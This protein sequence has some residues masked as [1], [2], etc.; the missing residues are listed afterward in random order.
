MRARS[1]AEIA[2]WF[3][4]HPCERCG[5]VMEEREFDQASTRLPGGGA[6]RTYVAACKQC[7]NDRRVDIEVPAT[8]PALE[9]GEIGGDQP[10]QMFTADELLAL[11]E[12]A[13]AG[14]PDQPA[15]LD[16]ERFFASNAKVAQALRFLREARKFPGYQRPD[17]D[18][19]IDEL[20]R[21]RQRYSALA[22]SM[23]GPGNSGG[24][25]PAATG[26]SRALLDAHKQWL[27]R[28]RTGAGRMVLDGASLG[29]LKLGSV[30]L[31]GARLTRVTLDGATMDFCNL[32][33]AEL[34][35]CS[36]VQTNF[37][38]SIL[39]GALL[40]RC[41]FERAALGLCDLVDTRIEGGS[42]RGAG[43]DRGK[44]Q[45]VTA[46]GAD[47]RDVRFGDAILDGSRFEGCDF[48]DADLGRITPALREITSTFNT[49]FIRCDLRG[50]RLEGRRLDGTRFIDC[51]LAGVVGKPVIE[52]N[53]VV[54]RPDFSASGDGSDVRT[55]AAVQALWGKP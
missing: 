51:K 24:R 22:A 38:H 25:T 12:R 46:S 27:A 19:R 30:K 32:A 50:A 1:A 55:A 18:R 53:Y 28:G 14:V 49:S 23:S 10:S 4:H 8:W 29:G 9:V 40:Q 20:Q 48:R 47:F 41:R 44:W 11:A 52:G 3:E 13:A 42:F 34:I 54:E 35:D 6:Q 43:A 16:R 36:A 33:G 15:G 45:R 21:Q 5:T 37:S 31:G 7:G 26:F 39:D 2:V 17:I